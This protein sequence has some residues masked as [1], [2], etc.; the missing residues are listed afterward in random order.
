MTYAIKNE[1][2]HDDI[3]FNLAIGN[4]RD[5]S[6]KDWINLVKV[7][8]NA[9]SYKWNDYRRHKAEATCLRGIFEVAFNFRFHALKRARRELVN[10]L[11]RTYV[12]TSSKALIGGENIGGTFWGN[13]YFES[14]YLQ[15][16]SNLFV[17][18]WWLQNR[19]IDEGIFRSRY[20]WASGIYLSQRTSWVTHNVEHVPLK[21]V[22]RGLE[23]TNLFFISLINMTTRQVPVFYR[24][25]FHLTGILIENVKE[26]LNC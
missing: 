3:V 23:E 26:N 11:L 9:R 15:I 4:S 6:C 7:L 17:M 19:E 18:P 10:N 2:P 16:P 21:V 5:F 22:S 25:N 20:K 1:Q 13:A 14:F 8:Y 12:H 24:S